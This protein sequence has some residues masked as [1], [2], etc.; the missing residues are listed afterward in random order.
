[1]PEGA[2]VVAQQTE[3]WMLESEFLERAGGFVTATGGFNDHVAI[4]LKQEQIPLMRAGGHYSALASQEAGQQATLACARFNDEPGAFIVAGDLTG[5][6]ACHRSLS[7]AFSDLPST[8]VIPSRDDLSPPEGA[9]RKVASGFQWLTD[10]NARLLAFFAP[11]GGLDCLANPIKLSMSPQRSK[12]LAETEEIVQR[13]IHG[14]KAQLNGYGAF[15]R[16]AVNSDSQQLKSRLDELPQLMNRFVTL[17]Q[18]IQSGLKAITLPSDDGKEGQVTFRQWVAACHQLQSCL[19]ALNPTEAEQ[20]RSVHDL[21]FA[22][23]QRFVNALAPVSLA[24]GQGRISREGSI[25]YLDCTTLDENVSILRPSDRAFLEKTHR[26]ATVVIM[27]NALIV[28]Q[29]LG[30]HFCLIELLE[31]AEGGK[32]RTLRLTFADE[33]DSPDGSDE[34]SKLKRMW[35]LVKL[36]KAIE[37]DK[38]ADSMK[39]SFNAVAGEIFVECSQMSSRGTMQEA[40]EKLIIVL[41]AMYNL[42]RW[43]KDKVIFE[44]DQWNFDLLAQRL[45]RDIATEADRFA[46]RDCLFTIAYDFCTIVPDFYSL[47]RNQHQQFINHVQC[48]SKCLSRELKDE[49]REMFKSNEID[50]DIRRQLLQHLLFRYPSG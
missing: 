12:I 2:I 48:L 17:E 18:T 30:N 37:L 16:L 27:D 49:L 20:L 19:Q 15:L 32:E 31:Y 4:L 46:F 45:N 11:G 1:M 29:K 38:N 47:L 41:N 42:D 50:A 6:L 23:H 21:I 10:Q 24:A 22:L 14:A 44:G 28:N 7:T 36:L 33:F 25:T 26:P 34:P 5:K 8:K 35:F 13:L 40:Y 39:L 3:D 43:L 9:F